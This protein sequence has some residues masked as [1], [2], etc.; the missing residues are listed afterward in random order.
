MYVKALV[1]DGVYVEAR[2]VGRLL[3]SHPECWGQR[4]KDSGGATKGYRVVLSIP[5]E[6]PSK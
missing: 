6:L 4:I 3:Y 2:I 5:T 1:D